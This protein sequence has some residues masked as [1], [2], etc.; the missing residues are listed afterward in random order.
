MSQHRLIPRWRSLEQTAR[1]ILLAASQ[2][3]PYELLGYCLKR[4]SYQYS[5]AS[6]RNAVSQSLHVIR[7]RYGAWDH[8]CSEEDERELR[9]EIRIVPERA[10]AP[11]GGHC[12]MRRKHGSGPQSPS[13]MLVSG[14]SRIRRASEWE[15]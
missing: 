14:R 5:T 10:S 7:D 6:L 9:G 3:P 13:E 8:R 4:M 2:S 1:I 12:A 15:A 11:L